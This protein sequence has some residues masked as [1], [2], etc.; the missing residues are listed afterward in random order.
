MTR[1]MLW[2]LLLWTPRNECWNA[3]TLSPPSLSFPAPHI[4][5]SSTKVHLCWFTT[6]Y[7]RF[8]DRMACLSGLATAL[9]W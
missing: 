7:L 1:V 6:E 8:I 5:S 9:S 4:R 2:A 3:T